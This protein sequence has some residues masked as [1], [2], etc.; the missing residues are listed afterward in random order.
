VADEVRKLA[1]R[2][3]KSTEEISIMIENIQ[4]GMSKA[5]TSMEEG[6]HYVNEGVQMAGRARESMEQIRVGGSRVVSSVN[7]IS[8]ALHEESAASNQVAQ[9][10]EK[11]ARMTEENSNEARQLAD[12]A[13]ELERLSHHLNEEAS[14]FRV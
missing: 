9:N 13:Q 6:S 1:E 4:S 7:D 14:R 3:S 12:A 2:T 5:V 8:A 10:V 11:I